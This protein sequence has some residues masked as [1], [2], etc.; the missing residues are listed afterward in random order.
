MGKYFRIIYLYVVSFITLCMVVCGFIGIVD[1][2]VGYFYTVPV[3]YAVYDVYD[4]DQAS[5]DN[6][7]KDV[8]TE[9]NAANKAAQRESIKQACTSVAVFACGLP[10]YIFH[11]KQIEKEDE[12]EE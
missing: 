11:T 4:D 8:E 3:N 5:L 1:G 9:K 10:L 6:I 2:I 7:S 12:K